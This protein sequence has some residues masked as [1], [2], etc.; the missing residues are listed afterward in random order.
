MGSSHISEAL[1]VGTPN[2]EVWSMARNRVEDDGAKKV[3]ESI[4][5]MKKLK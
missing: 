2:L 3:G 1:M 4:K 5:T